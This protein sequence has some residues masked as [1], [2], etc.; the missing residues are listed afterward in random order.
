MKEPR[1][2]ERLIKS[3][4][5]M[6]QEKEGT[7]AMKNAPAIIPAA[8]DD[9]FGVVEPATSSSLIRGKVLRFKD[10][11]YIADKT[12]IVELGTKLTAV[13]MTTCW[14]KWD[15]EGK[16][17]ETRVTASGETHPYRAALDSNDPKEWPDGLD[18]K[19]NDPWKDTRH[20]YLIGPQAEQ[21]TFVTATI[22][23]L[24]AV[25]E[26]KDQIALYRR[27]HPGACPVVE[28]AVADMPT[29]FGPK[30]RPSFKVVGWID[31][32]AN[33]AAPKSLPTTLSA[34]ELL[35]DE[36]PDFTKE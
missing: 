10:D 5:A 23:G 27:V 16:A 28:L 12:D 17:I 29:K 18:G 33:G 31:P 25:A 9:G 32:Q 14:V 34:G 3:A 30:S 11:N 1:E 20:V 19:P 8:A 4:T 13:A 2:I 15:A 26:L 36:I 7:T 21:Y 24:R 22:G 35:N 6:T